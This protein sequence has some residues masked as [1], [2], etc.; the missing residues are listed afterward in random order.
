[1]A[2]VRNISASSRLYALFYVL[3]QKVEKALCKAR[4]KA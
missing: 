2:A 1:V 3:L 4:K